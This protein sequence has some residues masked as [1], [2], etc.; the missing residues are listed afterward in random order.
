M[1]K[2]EKVKIL[3]RLL[4]LMKAHKA[5]MDNIK[6]EDLKNPVFFEYFKTSTILIDKFMEFGT[7]LMKEDENTKHMPMLLSL[8]KLTDDY[9]KSVENI[10][11]DD[12]LSDVFIEYHESSHFLIKE[13]IEFVAALIKDSHGL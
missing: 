6:K 5:S 9:E 2:E 11:F 4:E 10:P 8:Y 12:S 1:K 3:D 13:F 7:A